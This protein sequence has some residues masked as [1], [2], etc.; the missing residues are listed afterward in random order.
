MAPRLMPAELDWVHRQVNLGKTPVR[1]HSSLTSRR[2]RRDV[3]TPHLTALRKA[4]KGC[5][6]K[7]GHKVTRGRERTYS[8]KWFVS[9]NAA[10]KKLL[11]SC[12]QRRE[13]RC[14]DVV[15]KARASR[16]HRSTLKRAFDREGLKVAARRPREKP[17]GTPEHERERVEYC[18]EWQRKPRSFFMEGIDVII[19]NKVF[20]IP[21]S[22]RARR[23]LGA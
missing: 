7:R 19:D 17:Q 20:D 10:R 14:S 9:M 16:A 12:A 23:Q 13:V 1:I 6:Y 3:S 2:A 18:T 15:M 11:S 4:I 8:Q 5:T 21:T 22:E